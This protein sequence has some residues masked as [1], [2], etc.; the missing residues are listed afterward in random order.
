MSDKYSFFTL[1]QSV[2][3]GCPLSIVHQWPAVSCAACTHMEDLHGTVYVNTEVTLPV[4]RQ[5]R[6][7]FFSCTV[8]FITRW[9]CYII[10]PMAAH[11]GNINGSIHQNK[12][13][14]QK[15]VL[16]QPTLSC[17]KWLI[18]DLL[19]VYFNY[20]RKPSN[21]WCN[22][23]KGKLCNSQLKIT[24]NQ[25]YQIFAVCFFFMSFIPFLS[26]QPCGNAQQK[27]WHNW[28]YS[29]TSAF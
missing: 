13:E 25:F 15:S 29:H 28:G 22:L 21:E 14:M 1:E 5:Q 2:S 10:N 8:A 16:I 11:R 3:C 12:D 6:K 26:L 23:W 17:A 4:S 20:L 9:G 19:S 24:F 27:Q 18:I 7:Y